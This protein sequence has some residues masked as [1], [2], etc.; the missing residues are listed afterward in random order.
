MVGGVVAS[1]VTATASRSVSEPP[2]PATAATRVCPPGDTA[3]ATL[4]WLLGSIPVFVLGSGT[5]LY[6]C[7]LATA[8]PVR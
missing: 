8:N 2:C 4:A 6:C 7:G 5:D 1:G 3:I